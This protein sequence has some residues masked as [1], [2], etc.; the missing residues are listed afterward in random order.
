MIATFVGGPRHGSH[1]SIEHPPLTMEANNAGG[2][3]MQYEL[4]SASTTQVAQRIQVQVF[5]APAL[6]RTDEFTLLIKRLLVPPE[7][8]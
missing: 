5:Y 4:R 6:M 3:P 7:L 8:A 2:S 1:D